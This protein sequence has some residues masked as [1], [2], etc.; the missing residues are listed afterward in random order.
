MLVDATRRLL[1]SRRYRDVSLADILSESGLHT[2]AF[3][4]HFDT[5]DE[6][7][8]VIYRENGRELHKRLTARVQSAPTPAE[9]VAAWIDELLRL[10]F[11][12]RSV[13]YVSIYQDPA[14]RD[15][16]AASDEPGA[17]RHMVLAPL[18]EALA[19]GVADGSLPN[20]VPDVH[21]SFISALVWDD[22]NWANDTPP[23]QRR[24][25]ARDQLVRFAMGALGA[26]PG[27]GVEV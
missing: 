20:A 21:A 25:N 6:I 15:A 8:R 22:L 17:S 10:R 23:E 5:K 1:R 14:A 16:M 19:A 7:L 26:R 24:Q 2:R 18:V 27:T 4:R 11:E 12:P 3:Y 13:A 9:G